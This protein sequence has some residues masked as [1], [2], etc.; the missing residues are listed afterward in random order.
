MAYKIRLVDQTIYEV[1]NLSIVDGTLQ[2][3]FIGK[4]AEEVKEIMSNAGNMGSIELLSDQDLVLAY[5]YGFTKFVGVYLTDEYI[6]GYAV[7]PADPMDERVDNI[8]QSIIKINSTIDSVNST[9]D[10]MKASVEE[11]KNTANEITESVAE[12]TPMATLNKKVAVIIAQDFDDADAISVKNIYPLWEDMIGQSVKAGY[13]VL[14]KDVL[15]KTRQATTFQSHYE[16]GQTGM[17]SIFEVID[18]V[19][20]GTQDDPIPYDGN[21]ELFADKYYIQD[22]V[23]YKCTRGT[24]QAVTHALSAL[25]GLYVE[26][27]K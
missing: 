5:Y 26:V 18:E 7:K 3:D 10:D 21:M 12:I 11:M 27:V 25:V 4:T 9:A 16:P 6:R 24:G 13:K 1:D 15:Y 23:L 8:E 19:H 14:H 20:T 2:L 17:E 22:G